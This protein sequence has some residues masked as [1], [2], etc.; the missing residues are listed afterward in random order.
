MAH[1]HFSPPC[2]ALSDANFVRA[3]Q[4]VL[5]DVSSANSQVL[6]AIDH[7]EPISISLEEVPKVRMLLWL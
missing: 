7:F 4:S 5:R 3:L 6:G 2:Q 1:I